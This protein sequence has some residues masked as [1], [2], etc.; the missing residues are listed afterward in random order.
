VLQRPAHK[1]TKKLAVPVPPPPEIQLT[2]FD[3]LHTLKLV[4]PVSP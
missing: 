1:P 4:V 3:A 2:M